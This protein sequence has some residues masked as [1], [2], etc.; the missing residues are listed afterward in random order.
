M[1]ALH[2]LRLSTRAFGAAEISHAFVLSSLHRDRV[3]AAVGFSPSL[4]SSIPTLCSLLEW[5]GIAPLRAQLLFPSFGFRV[6]FRTS[7]VPR[8]FAEGI[9]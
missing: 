8:A 4:A 7:E 2:M 9:R 1:S 5:S 3:L 6:F